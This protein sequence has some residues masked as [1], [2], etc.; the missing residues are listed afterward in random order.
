MAAR[1]AKRYLVH[2]KY[3]VVEVLRA[4]CTSQGTPA[5]VCKLPDKTEKLLLAHAQY[6]EEATGAE[7]LYRELIPV[8]L[9]AEAKAR[10]KE[11][12]RDA[13]YEK[14]SL[15]KQTQASTV[16]LGEGLGGI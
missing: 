14:L 12:L 2:L 5:L 16:E 7:E 6:F 1:K 13:R 11:R 10:A 15:E 4:K 3:G 9:T 8:A